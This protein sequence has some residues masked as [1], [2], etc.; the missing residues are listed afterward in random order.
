[1]TK[2]EQAYKLINNAT[3]INNMLSVEGLLYDTLGISSN[4]VFHLD[5]RT[6]AE[7]AKLSKAEVTLLYQ[8]AS[9]HTCIKIGYVE[10]HYCH[11]LL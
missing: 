3:E 5:D 4:L 9:V 11:N 1:M 2:T 7:V 6:F 8:D 10:F